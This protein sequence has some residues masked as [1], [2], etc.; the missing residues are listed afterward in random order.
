MCGIC[1]VYNYSEYEPAGGRVL[2]GMLESIRHRGPDDEGVYIDRNL[3]LGM[4]RL[5]IIDLD[6]GKQPILNED[7]S[8]VLVFNGEI[9]NYRELTEQLRQR[10][11]TFTTASDT[12]VI[13]HLYEEYGDA[14]VH[15]LRGMFAF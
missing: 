13:V 10:G 12:E 5:S 9:Y 11:H 3:A 14:C 8:V 4:R 7:G 6:G 15:H 1:G 2:R